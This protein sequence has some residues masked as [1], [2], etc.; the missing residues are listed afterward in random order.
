MFRQVAAGSR[1]E[2]RRCT[3]ARSI[4]HP[5]EEKWRED[6]HIRPRDRREAQRKARDEPATGNRGG[7]LRRLRRLVDTRTGRRLD[8]GD[9]AMLAL[10]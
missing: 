2:G 9:R 6:E 3:V 1:L 8:R 5:E 4:P 10:K 7:N